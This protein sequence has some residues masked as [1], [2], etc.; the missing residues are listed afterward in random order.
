MRRA[1]ILICLVQFAAPFLFSDE[2][3]EET[4]ARILEEAVTISVHSE[5]V[6][7]NDE[8][9]WESDVSKVT[10]PGR[11]VT[12]LFQTASE[13]LSIELTPYKIDEASFMLTAVSNFWHE[14]EE[15]ANFRSSFK[16][17]NILLGELILFYPLGLKTQELL[18]GG[19]LFMEM[20]IRISPYE[21]NTEEQAE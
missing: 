4:L 5:I 1:F 21:R 17:V 12:L 14:G 3:D 15:G 2:T 16:S 13:K 7:H 19:N 11:T 20:G 9:Y 6:L 18:T 10:V 8:K